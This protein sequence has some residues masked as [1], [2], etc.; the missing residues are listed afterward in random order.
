MPAV[1]IYDAA[2]YFHRRQDTTIHKEQMIR[3]SPN[4]QLASYLHLCILIT[5]GA[6]SFPPFYTFFIYTLFIYVVSTF[7]VVLCGTQY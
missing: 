5:D 2:S 1:I 6:H 3:W 4:R 7:R